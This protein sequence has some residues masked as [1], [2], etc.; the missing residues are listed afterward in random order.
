MLRPI[1]SVSGV[2]QGSTAT[3]LHSNVT[4]QQRHCTATSLHSDITWPPAA[5]ELEG[6]VNLMIQVSK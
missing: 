6:S 2:A 1:S 5:P 4:A 3:S